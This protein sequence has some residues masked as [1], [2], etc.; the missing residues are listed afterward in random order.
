MAPILSVLIFILYFKI[1]NLDLSKP[2]FKYELDALFFSLINKMIIEEGSFFF[3]SRLSYPFEFYIHDFPMNSDMLNIFYIWIISKFSNDVIFVG[4]IYFILTFALISFTAFIALRFYK[5]SIFV[6][7][8]ISILYAFLPYHFFRGFFHLYLSNYSVIP[9]IFILFKIIIDGNLCL[10]EISKKGVAQF[11]KINKIN[12]VAIVIAILMTI[13][14]IYYLFYSLLIVSFAWLLNGFKKGK[15]SILLFANCFLLIFLS[16]VITIIIITPNIIF[17]LQ[18]SLNNSV[19]DRSEFSSE[20]FGFKIFDLFVPIADHFILQLANFNEKFYEK[21]YNHERASQSLGFLCSFG[22]V[23]LL[24]YSLTK[25]FNQNNFSDDRIND[26]SSLNLL[27]LL[28][29]VTSGFIMFF[30]I[31]FPW[32]RSHARF[33]VVISFISF[34]TIAILFDKFKEQKIFKNKHIPNLIILII[35]S[36]AFFDQVGIPSKKTQNLNQDFYIKK[37]YVEEIEN[38]LPKGAAI[39]IMPSLYF[40]ENPLDNYNFTNYYL[41]SKELKFS[42]PFIKS[43]SAYNWQKKILNLDFDDFINELKSKNFNAVLIDRALFLRKYAKSPQKLIDIENNL[44]KTSKRTIDLPKI[45]S[46]LFEI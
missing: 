30:V 2:I 1:Y 33:V 25:I 16:L 35:C 24:I 7:T 15:F 41:F 40:P 26:L 4:N 19:V 5:V 43:R 42:Y 38:T 11:S 6:A 13:N 31:I 27:S 32:F 8:L 39:F 9:L 22:F 10:I 36:I 17:W 14:G 46:I 45:N 34:I 18:N 3:S 44:K 21:F 20:F 23:Y 28:V 12:I 29:I 37:N